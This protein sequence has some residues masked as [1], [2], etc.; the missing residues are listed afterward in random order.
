MLSIVNVLI[1]YFM[2][3]YLGIDPALAG[4][5]LFATRLYDIVFDP[6]MGWLSDRLQTRWG[7]RRP[8]ML[9]ASLISGAACLAVFN[10]PPLNPAT[11][12]PLY[13]LLVLTLYF[14]GYTMFYIPFMAMPAEMTTN[15]DERTSIMSYR[16]FSSGAGGMIATALAPL[17][18]AYF[19]RSR[20]AYATTGAI[21]AAIIVATMLISVFATSK[22]RFTQP[23]AV[24]YAAKEWLGS[25]FSNKPMM[26]LIS[27]KLFLY[28][29]VSI[30]AGVGLFFMVSA[31]HR[32]EEGQALFGGLMNGVTLVVL[33]LWVRYAEGRVKQKVLIVAAFIYAIAMS[34]W[35]F[36][37]PSEPLWIFILRSS[38]VG[39]GYSGI[40]L[41]ILSM[42]PDVIEHDFN[43]TGLRREGLL[44]AIFAF[45]EKLAY[46][47]TPLTIGFLLRMTGY[48]HGQEESFIQPEAAILGLRIG[49][50]LLPAAMA[51][52][53]L[54]FLRFYRLDA[55]HLRAESRSGE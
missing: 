31:L 28:F 17:L 39:V 29:A 55:E 44:S 38:L 10:P 6:T 40:V 11:T 23:T 50:S 37:S 14:S 12:L 15:Y 24:R 49:E 36:S 47:F 2:V 21:I 30:H 5:V 45:V 16:T 43:R 32:G 18:V 4:T 41:M 13:M 1:M 54:V 53:G 25:V 52:V 35:I 22:A 48:V 51:I 27:A 9:L 42:L 20:E 7:R 46:A 8:W 34:S 33:P 26:A 3:N 19:G